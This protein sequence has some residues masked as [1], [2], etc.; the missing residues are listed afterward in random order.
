MLVRVGPFH[1][2]VVHQSFGFQEGNPLDE[3]VVK[4]GVANACMPDSLQGY[5]PGADLH[6]VGPRAGALL[7]AQSVGTLLLHVPLAA[8]IGDT[9]LLRQAV[10]LQQLLLLRQTVELQQVLDLRIAI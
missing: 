10:V 1:A 8:Q 4:I 6:V 5:L 7:A 3:L 2:G 9:L